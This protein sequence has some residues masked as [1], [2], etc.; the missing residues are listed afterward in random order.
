MEV[1]LLWLDELDDLLFAGFLAWERLRRHCLA[2]GF[3]AAAALHAFQ[4]W[5]SLALFVALV[6]VSLSSV[7]VWSVVSLMGFCLDR[8]AARSS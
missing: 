7:I 6:Y 1:I 3:L 2:V 8:R 4:S 5:G